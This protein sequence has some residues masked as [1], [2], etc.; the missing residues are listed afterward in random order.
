MSRW[1]FIQAQTKVGFSEDGQ[2]FIGEISRVAGHQTTPFH[3][4]HNH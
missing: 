2:E 1:D 4:S 3:S